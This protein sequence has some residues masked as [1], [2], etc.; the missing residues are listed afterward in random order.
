M[1]HTRD[2]IARFFALSWAYIGLGFKFLGAKI[3]AKNYKKTPD[4][5]TTDERFQ[6]VNKLV[7]LY[8]YCKGI[9]V[10]KLGRTNLPAKP[11]LYVANHKSN[12]DPL[13]MLRVLMEYP[14]LPKFVFV[15][16]KELQTTKIGPILDLIDTIYLDRNNPRSAF[17]C[18]D[19]QIKNIRDYK[20]N[21]VIFPEGTRVAGDEFGEFL[22]GAFKVAYKTWCEIQPVVIYNTDGQSEDSKDKTHNGNVDKIVPKDKTIDVYFENGIQ[23]KEFT[24]TK[25]EIFI[26]NLRKSMQDKYFKLKDK[27]KDLTQAEIKETRPTIKRTM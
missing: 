9:K 19:E 12:Y 15:A 7:K 8:L 21:I 2:K 22:N 16:K 18:F 24:A 10:Q 5:Y 25:E 3:A 6:K 1:S 20:R 17:K 27:H 4:F 14:Q 11:M 13:V 26:E 23:A